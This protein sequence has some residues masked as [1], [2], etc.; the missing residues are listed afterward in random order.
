MAH[1]FGDIA[2]NE[3][4]EAFINARGDLQDVSGRARFE[5][6]LAL[7]LSVRY[8]GLV[9]EVDKKTIAEKARLDAQ[10]VAEAMDELDSIAGLTTTYPE[11]RP[12][13]LEVTITYET[14]DEA[15]FEVEG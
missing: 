11:D 15:T 10:R 8:D 7:R 9:G 12:N 6:T 1:E 5:Q 13:V 4:F 3:N 2:L 14:G